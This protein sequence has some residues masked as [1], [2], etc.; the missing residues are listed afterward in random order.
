MKR[1]QQDLTRV[2]EEAAA[3]L[4]RLQT[5]DSPETRAEFDRWIRQGA[6]NL[7]EFLFAQMMLSE[8]DRLDSSFN[9]G[10]FA[11][12]DS[13]VEFP[14]VASPAPSPAHGENHSEETET[15]E[16]AASPRRRWPWISALAAALVLA[17]GLWVTPWPLGSN[18][19]STKVGSQEA[20]KLDD[21]SIIH[22]NTHSKAQVHFSK[23]VREVRL[24]QGEALFTVAHDAGRPFIVVTDTARVRAIGTQFNVYRS[25]TDQTKV[26]V[27]EGVVQVTGK[28]S[29]GNVAPTPSQNDRTA[30]AEALSSVRL[31][32]GDEAAVV[33]ARVV[34]AE[35]PAVERAV[36]W[37]SRRLMF[38]GNPVAEIAEEFNRYNAR[39]IR[40]EGEELRARKMTGVFDAD[41]PSTM[42]R[43]ISRDANVEVI[44]NEN[45][46]LIRP[47]S[48]TQE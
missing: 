26:S 41:D 4:L 17:T 34:K 13:V 5:E 37:R 19:Y 32:A 36:A 18:I 30:G 35:A 28:A 14:N 38:E 8:L 27:I 6:G 9:P 23:D 29:S 25:G 42:I 31:A 47:R 46:I 43:F 2:S 24:L 48:S 7:E 21:G 10:S 33:G 15:S 16:E 40:V 11:R 1:T 12:D 44:T 3:W 20:I 45:E 22:L 39:Q